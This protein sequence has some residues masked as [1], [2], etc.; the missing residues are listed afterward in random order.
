[1]PTLIRILIPALRAKDGRRQIHV[2]FH[3]PYT[4]L[5]EPVRRALGRLD[6]AVVIVNRRASEDRRRQRRP[7][8]LEWR[9]AERRR[10]MVTI[11]DIVME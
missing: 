1:M 9:Q 3:G 8:P 10:P 2:V 11:A 5:A 7:V 4:E 6:D